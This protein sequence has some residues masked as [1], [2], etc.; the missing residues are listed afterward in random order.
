[1]GELE[2]AA[3]AGAKPNQI[4]FAGVG[5][6]PDEIRRA[7]EFGVCEFNIESPGEAERIAAEARRLRK[8]AAV[9]LRLNPDVDAHTHDYISTGRKENKIRHQYRDRPG[10]H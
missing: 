7:L 4:I 2:R 6:R 5:K 3:R 9:A 10:S 1:M 8:T